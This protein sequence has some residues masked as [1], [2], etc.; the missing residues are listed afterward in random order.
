M[1]NSAIIPFPQTNNRSTR[2]QERVTPQVL[3]AEQSTLGAMLMSS[4]AIDIAMTMLRHEDFYRELHRK[5]FTVCI[6]LYMAESSVDLITVV[7]ELRRRQQL[8]EV[9]GVAYLT[10]LIEGCP[11]AANIRSYIQPL[12]RAS[13]SRQALAVTEVLSTRLYSSEDDG[14]LAVRDAM[15][16]LEE[17]K[18]RAVRSEFVEDTTLADLFTK[19]IPPIKWI[20]P[21]MVPEGLV[22]LAGKPKSGKSFWAL[23]LALSVAF[24][25]RFLGQIPVEQGDVLFLGLEDSERRIRDRAHPMLMGD[26]PPIAMSTFVEWPNADN[27]G[28]ERIEQWLGRHTRARLIVI[29]V[30]GKFKPARKGDDI[31]ADDYRSMAAL[32][33]LGDKHNVCILVLHHQSKSDRADPF[34]KISGT[35]A[36]GGAAD[37]ML[38]IDRKKNGRETTLHL[39]GRDVEQEEFAME[40]DA[41]IRTWAL[42]GKAEE[43]EQNSARDS[44]L[45]FL[46]NN[47]ESFAPKDLAEEL[48]LNDATVRST[49]RRLYD[50]GVVTR[51]G[52][53]YRATYQKQYTSAAQMSMP[54]D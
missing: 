30:L 13:V 37:A 46:R 6:D 22:I 48:E 4:D 35:A 18:E 29:D 51:D 53:K 50:E 36:I 10:A 11:G 23:A 41:N 8:D 40:W 44:I 12:I 42:L 1:R 47:S 33:T 21:D 27:G 15:S 31:Y 52:R 43:V 9:G 54:N 5:I 45:N 20:V 17:I 16:R 19:E 28:I 34:E 32:K 14:L 25:G 49:L 26:E 3:E 7:E 2:G 38:V 39:T 24:G